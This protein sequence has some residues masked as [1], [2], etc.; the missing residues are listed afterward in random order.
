MFLTRPS[1]PG[2]SG[3]AGT[4]VEAGAEVYS[5]VETPDPRLTIPG[6]PSEPS[7]QGIEAARTAIPPEFRD[8]PMFASDLLGAATRCRVTV[9]VECVNPIRSFK[10]RG[11]CWFGARRGPEAAARL[12]GL[13]PGSPG[14]VTG[15]AGNF[16]QGLAWAARRAGIPLTVFSSLHANPDKVRAMRSLGAGVRLVGEDF[17]AA[18]E[19]AVR[20]AEETGAGFVEDGREP[21]ITEGAGT[22]ALECLEAGVLA[23]TAVIPIGNGA[24]IGGMG[25]W[26]GHAA[27]ETTVVGVVAREAPVMRHAFLSGDPSPAEVAP[28]TI[29]DGI[30][31]RVPVPE[32]VPLMRQVVD[33]VVEVSEK[34]LRDAVRL[35]HRTLGL[36][37]EPAGAAGIAALLEHPDRFRGRDILTPLCGGNADPSLLAD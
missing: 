13:P 1:R 33:E 18:K 9:K 28:A 21:E 6:V 27:R 3:G 26:I 17:D 7:P 2:T 25:L 24:L 22:I 36:V 5:T 31:V 23:D 35:L 10:A 15:S 4:A 19:A 37:V 16:G 8:T 20:Y 32:A 14:W 11:A 12:R 30:A 29:A 34:A